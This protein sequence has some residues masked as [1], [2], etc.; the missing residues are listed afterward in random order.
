MTNAAYEYQ[1]LYRLTGNDRL[2]ISHLYYQNEEEFYSD[3]CPEDVAFLERVE[4]T[5][6]PVESARV[7]VYEVF[8]GEMQRRFVPEDTIDGRYQF[9]TFE[10]AKENWLNRLQESYAE[11]SEDLS[12]LIESILTVQTLTEDSVPRYYTES[13][14]T[15]EVEINDNA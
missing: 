5:R 12:K 7:E 11:L 15:V 8:G 1:W 6:R 2:I 3:F 10:Q 14:R 13:G 4:S 9:R